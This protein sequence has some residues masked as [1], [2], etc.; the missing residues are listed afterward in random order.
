MRIES[1]P[2]R[3]HFRRVRYTVYDNNYYYYYR[4]NVYRNDLLLLSLPLSYP[5]CFH[6]TARRVCTVALLCVNDDWTIC[7]FIVFFSPLEVF[8][9][10]TN[11]RFHV[12][13]AV[14]HSGMSICTV[15]TE[16]L[17]EYNLR[18]RARV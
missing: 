6:A 5:P 1:I 18:R 7:G 14:K 15:R 4:M 13:R 10:Q 16:V 9:G 17:F 3:R 12:V 2:I 8:A 11:T